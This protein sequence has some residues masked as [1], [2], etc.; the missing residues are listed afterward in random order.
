MID[1]HLH[2]VDRAS[3]DV[4]RAIV[5]A[6]PWWERVDPSTD[7]VLGRCAEAGVRRA[8][9]VQAVGAHRYDCS[10]L[11]AARRPGV[12]LV[13]AVDPFGTDPVGALEVLV[14]GG[15]AGLRLFAVRSPRP[16]LD[17]EVGR[18]LVARCVEVGVR[19]SVCVL[20]TEIPALVAL[21]EAFPDTEFAVD[22]M[23][24]AQREDDLAV[25]AAR[26]NLCPT[27]TPTTPL[28]LAAA[29]AR[30]GRDR[31]SWGSDHPQHGA[32]YPEPVVLGA[33]ARLWFGG[34]CPGDLG[35]S[36]Q[37]DQGGAG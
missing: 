13:G 31:L 22:H 6:E 30:F 15:I 35:P 34:G 37:A 19:P 1:A 9:L 3:A 16:W 17:S 8:V 23:A 2:V 29:V 11:L 20:P 24:F 32:D 33:A 7:A 36:M 21:A 14:A 26:E 18:S 10:Y 4:D 27:V 12:A 28:S 5:D 25:L